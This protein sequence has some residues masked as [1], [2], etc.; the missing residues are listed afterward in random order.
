MKTNVLIATIAGGIAAF[1]LGWLVYGFL[2]M[3][4][5]TQ[6]T[7]PYDGLFPSEPNLLA[8]FIS[9]L[10]WALLFAIVFDRW[11]GIK[12]FKSGLWAG[13]LIT[14]PIV[15]G[16]NVN[17]YGNMNLYSPTLLIVDTMVGVLFNGIVAGSVGYILG[18][19]D[20]TV[21]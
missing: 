13:M 14:F 21:A 1:L 2:L 20:K 10:C 3:D 15:L 7:I 16:Y 11:A 19:T 5:Y 12:D 8:I 18:K 17:Y 9:C 4:Y 6:N